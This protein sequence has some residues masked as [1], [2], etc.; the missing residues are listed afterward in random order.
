MDI[1]S[2]RQDY[3]IR[4]ALRRNSKQYVMKLRVVVIFGGRS[5]E[6][7]I[8]IRSART[9]IEAVDKS[10]YDVV[11]IAISQYGRWL[12]PSEAV[13]LLPD[14]NRASLGSDTSHDE[15]EPIALVGDT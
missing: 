10:K 14:Q 15:A 9:V 8:A 4:F 12:S 6:H 7:E 1:V 2:T 11:P 5:G 3:L 13:A